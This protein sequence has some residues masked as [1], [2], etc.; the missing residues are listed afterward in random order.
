MYSILFIIIFVLFVFIFCFMVGDRG[1][2]A[3]PL[4]PPGG[5]SIF[6]AHRTRSKDPTVC[7]LKS[8]WG[9]GGWVPI[10]RP[11]Q[12]SGFDIFFA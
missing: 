10:P 11:K 6:G 1:V 12:A 7:P 4:P 2:P 3:Q 5:T 9:V 8:G